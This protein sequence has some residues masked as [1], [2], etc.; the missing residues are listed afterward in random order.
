[1]KFQQVTSKTAAVR[2]FPPFESL[3]YFLVSK[4][5]LCALCVLC[6]YFPFVFD[7]PPALPYPAS[8][9]TQSPMIITYWCPACREMH[10]SRDLHHPT[11]AGESERCRK[12]GTTV[13]LRG[14]HDDPDDDAYGTPRCPVCQLEMKNPASPCPACGATPN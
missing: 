13:E 1:L 10:N 9:T 2:F 5:S 8:S 11:A 12:T 7:T 14:L 6:G 4:N 3:E